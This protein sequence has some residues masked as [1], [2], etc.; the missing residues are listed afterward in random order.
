MTV[1]PGPMCPLVRPPTARSSVWLIERWWKSMSRAR[2]K[3]RSIGAAMS[4]SRW[5]RTTSAAL[6]LL[7]LLD[8]ERRAGGTQR[9]AEDRRA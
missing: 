8:H 7:D 6:D 9:L 4:V 3:T 1:S 5:M 2:S